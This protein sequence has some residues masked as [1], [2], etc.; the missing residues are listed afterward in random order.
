MAKRL[1]LILTALA[2]GAVILYRGYR[3]SLVQAYAREYQQA[4]HQLDTERTEIEDQLDALEER[5][6]SNRVC[7][8]GMFLAERPEARLYSQ[9]APLLE[10]YGYTGAM[11]FS[12]DNYPGQPG[13]ITEE[14]FREL[15]EKGWSVCAAWDG[16][17]PLEELQ[18]V[19]AKMKLKKPDVIVVESLKYSMEMDEALKNAGYSV[20]IHHGE[21][22]PLFQEVSDPKLRHL[23]CAF[24]NHPNIASFLET[25]VQDQ[26]ILILSVD[27]SSVFADLDETLFR[28]MCRF[29][30]E[31][32]D[33]FPMEDLSKATVIDE[34]EEAYYQA[35]KTFLQEELLR[36][37]QQIQKLYEAYEQYNPD[38]GK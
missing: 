30:T 18:A 10:E 22:L 26:Q 27:F 35:R 21:D 25:A 19:F 33:V 7:G 36:C 5:K 29:M 3:Q 34:R 9:M 1:I 38:Q 17:A 8:M 20:V 24:W 32:E 2:V 16:E 4:Y 15:K 6:R 11:A 31:H 13:C 14:Q 23:S 37:D 12:V 28:N